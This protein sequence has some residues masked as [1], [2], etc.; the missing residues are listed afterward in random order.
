MYEINDFRV[1]D[2]VIYIPSHAK[3]DLTHKDCEKGIVTSLGEKFVFVRYEKQHP[4]SNGKATDARDLIY[5][6][7]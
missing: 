1:G 6:P 3:G 2:K 5:D 4:E 7:S